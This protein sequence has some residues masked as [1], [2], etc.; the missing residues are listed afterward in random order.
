MRLAPG[1]PLTLFFSDNALDDAMNCVIRSIP[2]ALKSGEED[3][4]GWG[5]GVRPSHTPSSRVRRRPGGVG[6][7]V[8]ACAAA[9]EVISF[10]HTAEAV[11]A[12]PVLDTPCPLRIVHCW[13]LPVP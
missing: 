6:G 3:G 13:I 9:A 10:R 4:W 1:G 12:P 5:V 7:K 2:H 11:S 8:A